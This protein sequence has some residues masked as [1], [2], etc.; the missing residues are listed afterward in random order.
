MFLY[1]LDHAFVPKCH[2]NLWF[3]I[4]RGASTFHVLLFRVLSRIYRLGEKSRVAEGDELPRSPKNFFE[5]NMPWDA[6]WCILGHN[7]WEMLQCVHW[8]RRVFFRYSYLY[9]VM[10]TVC[11]GGKQGVLFGE[12]GDFYPSNALDRT[13]LSCFWYSYRVLLLLL[14]LR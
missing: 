4:Q 7:F 11:F 6:I 8:P 10:I 12:G 14:W 2:Q 3:L 13:L 1:L 9:T 5:M